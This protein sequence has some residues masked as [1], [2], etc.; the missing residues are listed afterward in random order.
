MQM[1][2]PIY[3]MIIMSL[4][5]GLLSTMNIWTISYNHIRFHLNDVYMAILMTCWM[6]VLD[7]IYYTNTLHI[8]LGIF[9]VAITIY[10]IRNQIFINDGQ[11]MKGMIPHHSMA[12]L[13]ANKIKEK[14]T[15]KNIIDLANNIIESQNKEIEYMQK[16]GY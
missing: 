8:I 9:G 15:D 12:I 3:P 1:Q 4:I 16:L 6:V 14:S 10:L 11:F 2:M 13:M 7:G 5:A